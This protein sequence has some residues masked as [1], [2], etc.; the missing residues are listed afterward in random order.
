MYVEKNVFGNIF[1]T[2]MDV[3]GKANDNI[4]AMM[5]IKEYCRHRELELVAQ[6]NGKYLKPNI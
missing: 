4:K 3:K 5:D 2:V 1:N 6:G